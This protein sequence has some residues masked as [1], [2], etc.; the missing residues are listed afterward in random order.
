MSRLLKNDTVVV[1][2]GKDKGKKGKVLRVMPSERK[3][4]VENINMQTR[5]LR[6]TR[7]NPKGG[8]ASFEGLINVTDLML[9]CP[10][11]QKNT[12]VGYMILQDKTKRRVCKKCQEII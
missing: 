12:R 2:A 4:I 5:H 6:P 7:E 10:R 3:A 9:V 1:L 8:K 11:C